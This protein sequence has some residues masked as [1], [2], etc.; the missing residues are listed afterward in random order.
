MRYLTCVFLLMVLVLPVAGQEFV[1]HGVDDFN[2][3]AYMF[4]HAEHGMEA[5]LPLMKLS[6]GVYL[7]MFHQRRLKDYG[8]LSP[9]I[10]IVEDPPGCGSGW[11]EHPF[12]ARGSFAYGGRHGARSIDMFLVLEDCEI[13]VSM[14]RNAIRHRWR[15]AVIKVMELSGDMRYF[16]SAR[17]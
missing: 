16:T 17:S 2:A 4:T 12:G 8:E 6:P 3:V 9:Q 5:R 1:I 10:Q 7:Y 13:I 15:L 14:V 11:N